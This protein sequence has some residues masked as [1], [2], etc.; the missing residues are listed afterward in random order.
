MC[1][2]IFNKTKLEWNSHV[3]LKCLVAA[4]GFGSPVY[5]EKKIVGGIR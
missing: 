1:V 4:I 3:I 2:A 5:G